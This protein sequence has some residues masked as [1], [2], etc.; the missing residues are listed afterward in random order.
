M[1]ERQMPDEM[2]TW[3]IEKREDH[4]L[5][6]IAH[7]EKIYNAEYEC[8]I[9]TQA[10]LQA[11]IARAERLDELNG[12]YYET[13]RTL[14]TERDSLKAEVERLQ[15][16]IELMKLMPEWAPMS[17]VQAVREERNSALA[18]V[19]VLEGALWTI[20]QH[21]CESLSRNKDCL[22]QSLAA[23]CWPCFARA[24]LAGGKKA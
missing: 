20:Q 1:S 16:N 2:L 11:A 3:P 15:K 7:L 21:R 8:R 9:D 18:R 13:M 5:R 10:Q 6:H 23:K 24:A 14:S 22:E 4:H 12:V 17:D 19:K